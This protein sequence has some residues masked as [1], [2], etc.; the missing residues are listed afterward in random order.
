VRPLD[1]LEA[2]G[3]RPPSGG[4]EQTPDRDEELEGQV[5]RYRVLG[6]LGRG[7][8]GRVLA[9]WDPDLRREVAVKLVLEPEAV[10]SA[11]LVRFVAEA[12]TTSQLDHPNIVPI[13]DF[14]VSDEGQVF[15][16]M[17][18]VAGRSLREVL[19]ALRAG[20]AATVGEWTRHRL[21]LAF[22]Q[23]CQAVGYAH[24]RGVLHRDIKP[25]N[26]M[27]GRFGEVLVLDWGV[28]RVGRSEAVELRYEQVDR[29]SLARTMD[30]AMIGTPGF[31]SPEQ[32]RGAL[33]DLDARSDVWSLG[34]V[35]YQLLAL[36]PPFEAP[37]PFAL[38]LAA[39][40]EDPPPP[41]ERRGGLQVHPEI[42]GICRRAMARDPADRFASALELA[43]AVEGFLEGSERRARE[44]RRRRITAVVVLAVLVALVAASAAFY[45]LWRQAEI[46]TAEAEVRALLAESRRHAGARSADVA[47]ALARAALALQGEEGDAEPRLD[48]ELLGPGAE[49]AFEHLLEVRDTA[50]V[51]ATSPDRTRL[52]LGSRRGRLEILDTAGQV[53]TRLADQPGKV[54]HLAFA[55]DGAALATAGHEQPTRLWDAASGELIVELGEDSVG[56][57]VLTFRST[58]DQLVTARGSRIVFWS[59]EGQ[60]EEVVETRE[61]A[62]HS[63]VMGL[64][65][66]LFAVG[67][68]QA[69][70]WIASPP[71]ERFV[72]YGHERVRLLLWS[73]DDDRVATADADGTVILWL[74][75]EVD[76]VARIEAH[77]G[78]VDRMAFSPDGSLLA[79][80]SDSEVKIWSA[81]DGALVRRLDGHVE[82]V[83]RLAFSGASD[84]LATADLGRSVRIWDLASGRTQRAWR[85]DRRRGLL[86]D[87]RWLAG[88]DRLAVAV[89]GSVVGL[90]AAPTGRAELL[91]ASASWTSHLVCRRSLAVVP[92]A[93]PVGPEEVWAPP[94]S[95]TAGPAPTGLDQGFLVVPP[96]DAE[97]AD[98]R[99]S[100]AHRTEGEVGAS[101]RIC[102]MADSDP[103]PELDVRPGWSGEMRPLLPSGACSDGGNTARWRA[104]RFDRS[105]PELQAVLVGGPAELRGELQRIPLPAEWG[106]PGA[107][108]RCLAIT[109][110]L[111]DAGNVGAEPRVEPLHQV[112]DGACR[113]QTEP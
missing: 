110:Q 44:A 8:M 18:R 74:M 62:I 104:A 5:G 108:S 45:R 79:T 39:A 2:L 97:L 69:S 6:E 102:V 22:I 77:P 4:I 55:P 30:G 17:K 24:E 36:E 57:S 64:D 32:A 106:E 66:I 54:S 105:R 13:H 14:G 19:D 67:G 73:P 25:D 43:R 60:A 81:A 31:M 94:E 51:L 21:L 11:R 52:A 40:T 76:M 38:I 56:P 92:A 91:E 103:A 112:V 78:P 3:V 89:G 84:R 101:H 9:A 87:L 107:T 59:R 71:T 65:G 93:G 99:R 47:V 48:L 90:E 35:L 109:L 95:C 1:V 58:E 98:R 41:S 26:V 68:D 82:P 63:V 34:S 46:A 96:E 12:Q 15:F 10:S 33:D 111:D 37:T 80:A 28:A 88:D 86:N 50:G 29:V 16:V 70:L 27:L 72:L 42:E 61:R 83:T 23:V 85:S 49:V 75:G 100:E 7:G 20:D 53:V 113:E